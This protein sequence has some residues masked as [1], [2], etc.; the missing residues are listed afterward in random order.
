MGINRAI[1]SAPKIEPASANQQLYV[2]TIDSN[3]ITFGV[4]PAGTGKTFLAILKAM[5]AFLNNKVS[6]IVLARPAVESGEKI[7]FL[8]GGIQEKMDPF[9]LNLYDAM[10]E[11]WS[12]TAIESLLNEGAI[13]I[14]PIGFMRG[15]TFRNAF[16]IVDEAQNLTKEQ[17][18]MVLTRFGE[19]SKMVINGDHL[20][21]DLRP[22]MRGSLQ[23]AKQLC[24][25]GIDGVDI[26]HLNS[27]DDIRRHRV[28]ADITEVWEELY[29]EEEGNGE[30]IPAREVIRSR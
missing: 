20:Q 11:A 18:K 17:L 19:D 7:G 30:V 25:K 13:E 24:D 14:C 22:F 8:P 15:R 3:F 6:K 10:N 4:G 21:S 23:V 29:G 2:D 1:L 12:D 28:V 16:I 27:P 9:M 26:V 5:E